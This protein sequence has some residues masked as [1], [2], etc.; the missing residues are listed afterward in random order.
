MQPDCANRPGFPRRVL[1][2]MA[3]AL[4]V[5][6]GQAGVATHELGHA[7]ERLGTQ[8][9]TGS[10]AGAPALSDPC[11]PERG[12]GG[13]CP[14]HALFAELASIAF[15]SSPATAAEKAT[16]APVAFLDATAF[17]AAAVPFRSRAPPALPA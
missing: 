8:A 11:H 9:A 4:C 3:L 5:L 7:L 16:Q 10:P 2:A 15:G 12:E 13:A 6:A 14:L 1:L 17:A